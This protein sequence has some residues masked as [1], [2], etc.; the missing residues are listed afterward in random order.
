MSR[1]KFVK[2][3]TVSLLLVFIS[4]N[5]PYILKAAELVVAENEIDSLFALSLEELMNVEVF[6]TTKSSITIQKS[7]G[8]I[9]VFTKKDFDKFGFKTLK[10]VLNVVPGIQLPQSYKNHHAV[11]IRGVQTRYNSKVLL[12]IDGVPIRGTYYGH[13]NI[14]QSVTL[15]NVERIEIINGPGSVLYGANA[16]SGVISITTKSKGKSVQ[17][18]LTSYNGYGYDSE[19][20]KD[21]T[22][23]MFGA[24]LE[25]DYANFY[26]FG[27]YLTGDDFSPERT[28]KGEKYEHDTSAA[29]KY[30]MA[31]YTDKNWTVIAA[32]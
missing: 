30:L 31:K 6:S 7:P 15:G 10:D 26:G 27:E 28:Q 2:F 13:F 18:N 32:I 29:K 11:W 16:F 9:R 14:D 4:F 3:F 17:A 1:K 24:A 12:L 19:N 22:F 21:K 5:N 20:A 25:G 23:N 8:V